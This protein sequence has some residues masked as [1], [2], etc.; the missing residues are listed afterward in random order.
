PVIHLN[1]SKTTKPTARIKTGR[2]A[3]YLDND[4]IPSVSKAV[5]KG[6]KRR[7]SG[8]RKRALPALKARQRKKAIMP[9]KLNNDSIEASGQKESSANPISNAVEYSKNIKSSRTR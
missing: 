6:K 5:E 8:I 9:R 1:A 2:Q 7:Q 4:L 3:S